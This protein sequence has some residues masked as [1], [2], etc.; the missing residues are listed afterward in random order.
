MSLRKCIQCKQSGN[1][2]VIKPKHAI[3]TSCLADNQ[4]KERYGYIMGR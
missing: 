4:L 2:V 3:C 1:E